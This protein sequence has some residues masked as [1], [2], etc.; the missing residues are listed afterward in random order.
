MSPL[1]LARL[2]QCALAPSF[3]WQLDTRNDTRVPHLLDI[4]VD[5]ISGSP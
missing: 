1:R 3:L 4:V 2:T 5:G